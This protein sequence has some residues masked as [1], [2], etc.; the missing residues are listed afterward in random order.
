[1]TTQRQRTGNRLATSPKQQRPSVD[2]YPARLFPVQH[3]IQKLED[4]LSI[5]NRRHH[6]RS[7]RST[8]SGQLA[9]GNGSARTLRVGIRIVRTVAG[10]PVGL[11]ARAV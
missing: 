9:P 5:T 4:A 10:P 7:A 3:E 8:A 11:N 6:H 1:M 2:K